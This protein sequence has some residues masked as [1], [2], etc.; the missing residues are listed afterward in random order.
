MLLIIVDSSNTT[1]ADKLGKN[2]RKKAFERMPFFMPLRRF[3]LE[4]C[5]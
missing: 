2:E 5:E 4:G 1:Y 3:F